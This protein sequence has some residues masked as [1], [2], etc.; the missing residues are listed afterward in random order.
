MSAAHA[1]IQMAAERCGA[2][3][4]DGSQHFQMEPVQ[5]PTVLFDEAPART[6]N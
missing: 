3:A 2:A 1:L 6:A 4:L 5:P